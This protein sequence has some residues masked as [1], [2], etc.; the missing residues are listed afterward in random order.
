MSESSMLSRRAQAELELVNQGSLWAILQ[1]QWHP[2]EN[3]EGLVTLGVAENRL[4]HAELQEHINQHVHLPQHALT[5]GDGPTGSKRHKRAVARFLNR[6]IDPAVPLEMEHIIV[7]NGVSDAIE[8]CSW[9]FCNKGEGFLLGRPHYTS[10]IPDIASRPEVELVTVSFGEVDPVSLEGVRNYEAALLEAKERGVAVRALML[11]NPH[12]P[13]GRCY[14]RG[15]HRI[16]E[17]LPEISVA[18]CQRRDIC[19]FGLGEQGRQVSACDEF[20]VRLVHPT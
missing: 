7:T 9:S 5:Y 12:N 13:L 15:D 20:R 18:F 14:Q 3:A 6:H 16:D 10:F 8:H 17:A 2:E 11:C 1:D 19:I 4:M